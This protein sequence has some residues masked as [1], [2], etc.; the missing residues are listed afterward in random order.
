MHPH[1]IQ[2][3][4]D[5][6]KGHDCATCHDFDNPEAFFSENVEQGQG[7]A[8]FDHMAHFDE[9][10][11]GAINHADHAPTVT[12]GAPAWILEGLGDRV[13]AEGNISPGDGGT[14]GHQ[15]HDMGTEL[16]VHELFDVVETLQEAGFNLQAE[17]YIRDFLEHETYINNS[18]HL[19]STKMTGA[20]TAL[21][22]V[23][24][25]LTFGGTRGDPEA[26]ELLAGAATN[27]AFDNDGARIRDI[28][29]ERGSPILDTLSDEQLVNIWSPNAHFYNHSVL[30][31]EAADLTHLRS[32]NDDAQDGT[33]P[34]TRGGYNDKG[35]FRQRTD[36]EFEFWENSTAYMDSIAE[37]LPEGLGV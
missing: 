2:S 26:L 3:I 32:L 23:L 5:A 10:G 27:A 35:A 21:N 28:L 6:P 37:F 30:Q 7:A 1:A 13:D 25:A 14:S 15:T 20:L 34:G 31:G 8:S 24:A 22:D 4:E 17:E 36:S 18:S 11:L 33:E 29:S 12:E 19:D 9:H 16:N